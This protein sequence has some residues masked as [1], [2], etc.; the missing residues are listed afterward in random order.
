MNTP[1]IT[2]MLENDEVQL[3][4]E[5]NNIKTWKDGINSITSPLENTMNSIQPL[6]DKT[7]AIHEAVST[8]KIPD[9]GNT[10]T[11]KKEVENYGQKLLSC[12]AQQ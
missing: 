5:M 10:N 6:I 1:G 11:S 7:S 8:T 4:K 12:S 3:T 2:A 9:I